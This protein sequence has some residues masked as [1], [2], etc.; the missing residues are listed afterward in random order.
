MNFNILKGKTITSI[1]GAVKGSDEIIFNCSDGSQYRLL[2]YQDCCE[3]VEIEDI[4]GDINDLIGSP[5]L[6]ADEVENNNYGNP[7]SEYDESFT[8]TFY[9]LATI[10]GYVDIR[11]YGTSNGYYSERVDFI[12]D[13]PP[14]LTDDNLT[15]DNLTNFD[16]LKEYEDNKTS[17]PTYQE[18]KK[19]V[20]ENIELKN[21]IKTIQSVISSLSTLKF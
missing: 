1:Y 4:C 7:R 10:Y 15:D 17:L 8:W 11:W 13:M 19:L 2:H 20:D 14:S 21:S 6:I 12:E 3:S 5:I 9:K 16:I 18:Y